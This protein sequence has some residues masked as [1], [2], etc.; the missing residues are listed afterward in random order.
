[1]TDYVHRAGRT[2]RVGSSKNCK[3]TTFVS[4]TPDIFLAQKLEYAVRTGQPIDSLTG[5]IK[6]LCREKWE[7]KQAKGRV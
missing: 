2:G 1:V 3:V 7:E 6:K 4:F 5:D